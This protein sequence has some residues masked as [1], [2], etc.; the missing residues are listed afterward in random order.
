MAGLFANILPGS[1]TAAEALRARYEVACELKHSVDLQRISVALKAWLAGLNAPA[2][3]GV[4][5]V[6]CESEA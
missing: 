4:R 5:I 1:F 3:V 6:A 2:N